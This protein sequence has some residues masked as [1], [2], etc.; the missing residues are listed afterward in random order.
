MKLTPLL[1]P[2]CFRDKSREQQRQAKLKEFAETGVMPGKKQYKVIHIKK[3]FCTWHAEIQDVL[4]HTYYWHFG[5][6]VTDEALR[7]LMTTL[8][9]LLLTWDNLSITR[10][11]SSLLST[12]LNAY[13]GLVWSGSTS[14]WQLLNSC[15]VNTRL[16]V[17]CNMMH[18]DWKL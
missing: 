13:V 11:F 7:R 3:N 17:E 8:C 4:K 5:C 18:G 14:R 16:S 1:T 12:G 9:A 15:L 10:P 6:S 2:R